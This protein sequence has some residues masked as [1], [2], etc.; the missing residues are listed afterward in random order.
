MVATKSTGRTVA[1]QYSIPGCPQQPPT[2]YDGDALMGDVNDI[3]MIVAAGADF[4]DPCDAS[5]PLCFG[6]GSP[7]DEIAKVGGPAENGDNCS[8]YAP[9]AVGAALPSVDGSVKQ[10]NTPQ[11][12]LLQP[13]NPGTI[14]NQSTVM[15]TDDSGSLITDQP[16][17]WVVYTQG[18]GAW[19]TPNA[20]FAF[21]AG[22]AISIGVPPA[23]RV[24]MNLPTLKLN[25]A[26]RGATNLLANQIK[27]QLNG[28]FIS[29]LQNGTHLSNDA[30]Y[31]KAAVT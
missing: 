29:A 20:G 22:V 3:N 8:P 2:F 25:N 4:I 23:I 18:E 10:I 9:Y 31:K 1:P 30:C 16:L 13:G 11:G 14:V 19:F 27:A 21:G 6:N 12:P 15:L 24:N 28:A 17:G 26:I 7:N 5:S